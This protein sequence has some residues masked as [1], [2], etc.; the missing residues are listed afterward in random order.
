MTLR[1]PDFYEIAIPSRRAATE[2]E[3]GQ[4]WTP[5][6]SILGPESAH[7][8]SGFGFDTETSFGT[9]L[10]RDLGRLGVHFGGLLGS[11]LGSVSVSFFGPFFGRH[12]GPSG[13]GLGPSGVP[14]GV[15]A[16]E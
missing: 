4:K 14:G 16:A 3:K 6:R 10:G 11:H 7:F 12:L 1:A 5:N 13:V 9:D 15:Y 2:T 8:G